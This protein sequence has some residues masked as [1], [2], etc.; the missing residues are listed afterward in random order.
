MILLYVIL[1]PANAQLLNNV[2]SMSSQRYRNGGITKLYVFYWVLD[3]LWPFQQQL[4]HG[5]LMRGDGE[6][7]IIMTILRYRNPVG[8]QR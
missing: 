4:K 6:I 1:Y 8:T 3:L 7:V 5:R 2:G